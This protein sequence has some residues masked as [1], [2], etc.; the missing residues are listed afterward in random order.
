ML[1]PATRDIEISNFVRPYND[2]K[3]HSYVEQAKNSGPETRSG[4]I[5]VRPELVTEVRYF[6]RYRGGWMRDGV[7]LSEIT[8]LDRKSTRLN[9]SHEFVSRMPSSA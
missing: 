6:G 5:P 3:S 4:L 2:R 8:D 9:S 7:L 1:C